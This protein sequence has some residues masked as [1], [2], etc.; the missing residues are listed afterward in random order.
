MSLKTACRG[1]VLEGKCP[2]NATE[3]C[4]WYWGILYVQSVHWRPHEDASAFE[5]QGTL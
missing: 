2:G 4:F 3:R 5:L 1:S